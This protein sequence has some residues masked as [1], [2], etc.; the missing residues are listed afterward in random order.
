[1]IARVSV[2]FI[3]RTGNRG[4]PDLPLSRGQL[5]GLGLERPRQPGA[6][7]KSSQVRSFLLERS[8]NRRTTSK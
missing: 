8:C 2:S 7:V 4:G 6:T 5:T 3:I 1:V